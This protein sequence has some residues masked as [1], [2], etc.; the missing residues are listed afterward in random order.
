MTTVQKNLRI[1]TR[2]GRN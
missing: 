2:T 1:E